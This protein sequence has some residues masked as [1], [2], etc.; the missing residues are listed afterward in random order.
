MMFASFHSNETTT[1][2]NDK[3]NTVASGGLIRS[4][5]STSNLGGIPSTPGDVLSF[6]SLMFSVTILGLQLGVLNSLTLSP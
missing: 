5:I 1:S 2:S 3:L 6:V 4:T